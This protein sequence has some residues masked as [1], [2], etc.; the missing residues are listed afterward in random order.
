MT[1]SRKNVP[2]RLP[3]FSRKWSAG[4]LRSPQ[5]AQAVAKS[6]AAG[7]FGV[8][9]QPAES[10]VVRS[11]PAL[12][13]R[14]NKFES[15]ATLSRDAFLAEWNSAFSIFSAIV[16]AEFQIT[17]ID[18]AAMESDAPSSR[19]RLIQTRVR[20]EITGTGAGFH[21]EQRVGHWDMSMGAVPCRA[22][23]FCAVGACSTKR[24]LAPRH[25]FT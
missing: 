16:S 18:A 23:F 6:L 19:S 1:S 13:V 11:S 2:I 3:R 15:Q 14:R 20:Y 10:G 9:L 17:A 5:D 21:R 25:P 24:R 12:Q 4:L 8:P 7:F 22:S